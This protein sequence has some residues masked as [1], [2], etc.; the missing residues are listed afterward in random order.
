MKRKPNIYNLLADQMT[1]TISF[2]RKTDGSGFAEN[3]VGCIKIFRNN[4]ILL[5]CFID[6]LYKHTVSLTKISRVCLFPTDLHE[7]NAQY[8][9]IQ[10]PVIFKWFWI[11]YLTIFAST[12]LPPY[13]AEIWKDIC[14]N[15]T[16]FMFCIIQRK[17]TRL[18]LKW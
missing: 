11:R 10:N 9:T 12:K 1:E 13:I 7:L 3:A 16:G 5:K 2:C 15:G 6:I 17:T 18:I 14:R 8:S 4:T